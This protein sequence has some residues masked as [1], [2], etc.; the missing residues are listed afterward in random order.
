VHRYTTTLWNFNIRRRAAIW[1]RYCDLTINHKALQLDIWCTVAFS[2]K[3]YCK[4][5]AEC[6]C[7][8]IF[9]ISD[10]WLSC[11]QKSWL[12]STLS[13]SGHCPAK[14]WRT[15]QISWV[16]QE[17]AVVNLLH[18]FW[19]DLDNYQTGVDQ[20]CL[21]I[22]RHQR[23]TERWLMCEGILL[24]C[25]GSCVQSVIMWGAG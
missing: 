8:R 4:F 5:T 24:P 12:P 15:R 16:W 23:L 18:W 11:R 9:K 13:V 14:R 20:F 21:A 17:T 25:C 10:I 3:I 22:W 6:A 19:L 1:N 7:K 2:T